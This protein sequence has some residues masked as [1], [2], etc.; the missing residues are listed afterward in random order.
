M[1]SI[2]LV[3]LI[4]AIL[5]VLIKI[6]NNN[7]TFQNDNVIYLFWTGGYDS[8]FRLCQLT[9][10]QRKKVQPIYISDP[11]LDN[12]ESKNTKRH[13]HKQ[14]YSA[15]K[16]IQIK[17]NNK[18]PYTKKLILPII[19][20]D[21]IVLDEDIKHNMRILHQQK[22]VRRAVCQY[23][24]MAQVTKNLDKDIEICVENAHGSMMNRT[25]K[26]KLKCNH[27]SCKYKD[28]RLINNLNKNDK[29][30]K[31]FNRFIF[32]TI[33]LT[34]KDMYNIA[35]QNKFNDI[36][37]I[38]WSCWYPRNNKPCGRCVMCRERIN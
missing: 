1:K 18:F 11:N 21:N 32:S 23:G 19:D 10:I 3:T 16:N 5:F 2:Y 36:L 28:L 38:T 35:Q 6:T 37:D 9:I 27:S 25:I 30:L 8:T 15:M 4:F 26:D 22:R 34:K 12:E 24:G 33:F 14:E 31:I 29:S 7:E 13:N 17:I 20:I